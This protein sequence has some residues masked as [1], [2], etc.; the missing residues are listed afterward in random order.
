MNGWPPACAVSDSYGEDTE[1][2]E[3]ASH[4]KAHLVN[5]WESNKSAAVLPR[6][7][8]HTKLAEERD[9]KDK[10]KNAKCQWDNGGAW[11]KRHLCSGAETEVGLFLRAAWPRW[12]DPMVAVHY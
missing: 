4:S 3:E 9:L 11:E 8:L 5:S 12:E 10:S 7:H 1:K 2:K 6:F